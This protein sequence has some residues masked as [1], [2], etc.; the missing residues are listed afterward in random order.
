M[1]LNNRDEKT[2]EWFLRT[3]E[4]RRRPALRGGIRPDRRAWRDTSFS[5]AVAAAAL[6]TLIVLV[7]RL[8]RVQGRTA[9]EEARG[10]LAAD[11]PAS[12]VTIEPLRRLSTPVLPYGKEVVGEEWP[13][14]FAG[15][16]LHPA[17]LLP[18]PGHV[19]PSAPVWLDRSTSL[20]GRVSLL[21]TSPGLP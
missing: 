12:S 4:I 21:P 13:G 17:A 15:A 7:P 10:R 5:L 6:A 16:V 18:P 14:S 1:P 8:P 3:Q 2:Q 9:L 11:Y 20:T 19:A